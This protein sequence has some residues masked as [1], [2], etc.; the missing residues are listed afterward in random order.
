MNEEL[1]KDLHLM[2]GRL[3]GVHAAL[4]V[5]AGSLPP[6][7]AQAAASKLR[8]GAERVHADALALPIADLQIQE[9]HRVMGELT[10][11]LETAG[12]SPR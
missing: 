5:I 1:M 7:I 2:L 10:M 9:M 12:Q 3:N 6:A 8:E 11:V 4:T